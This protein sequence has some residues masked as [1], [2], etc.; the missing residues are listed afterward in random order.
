MHGIGLI[1]AIQVWMR[2]RKKICTTSILFWVVLMG[3][4][5]V[6]AN[7]NQCAQMFTAEYPSELLDRIQAKLQYKVPTSV[8]EAPLKNTSGDVKFSDFTYGKIEKFKVTETEVLYNYDSLPETLTRI[9]DFV[10]FG[11]SF[12]NANLNKTYS[13]IKKW[14][15]EGETKTSFGYGEPHKSLSH[16]ILNSFVKGNPSIFVPTTSD[17]SKAMHFA[18]MNP[19]RFKVIFIL[20]LSG[21]EVLNV[22][23]FISQ[24]IT[25]KPFYNESEV[26]LTQNLSPKRIVGAL[27]YKG[28]DKTAKELVLNPN[29]KS[30]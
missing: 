23:A 2:L 16:H 27:I 4:E 1:I 5:P 30:H 6:F 12:G 13:Y 8:L 18:S 3:Y 9:N 24:L 29:Y 7:L 10:F 19:S 25:S 17:F 14:F 20:D 11:K 28:E 15:S 26:L 21:A 22:D